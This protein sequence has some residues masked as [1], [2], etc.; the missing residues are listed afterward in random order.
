MACTSRHFPGEYGEHCIYA[1]DAKLVH[2]ADNQYLL[3]K[4]L[5][6]VFALLPQLFCSNVLFILLALL[7]LS[8][9]FLDATS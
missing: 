8:V 3:Q 1:T 9:P 6:Q 5:L 4:I 7:L 2:T